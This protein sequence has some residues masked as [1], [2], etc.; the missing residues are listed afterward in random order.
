MDSLRE[1]STIA[2]C[3]GGTGFLFYTIHSF[4]WA[5]TYTMVADSEDRKSVAKWNLVGLSKDD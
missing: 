2:L 4:M 5:F 1:A 3:V